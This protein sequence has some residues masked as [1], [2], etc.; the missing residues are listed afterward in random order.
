MIFWSVDPGSWTLTTR[1]ETDAMN[2]VPEPFLKDRPLSDT[3]ADSYTMPARL[4]T[5]P[6]V[7]EQEKEAIFAKSWHYICLLYT[8]PSP[9]D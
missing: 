4:Y 1:E 8:S 7:F 5:D 6:D 3:A 2:A 9:R